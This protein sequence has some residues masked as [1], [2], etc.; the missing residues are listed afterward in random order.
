MGERRLRV[1]GVLLCLEVV[2][3]VKAC[4]EERWQLFFFFFFLHLLG[5]GELFSD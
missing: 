2:Q 5:Y 1:P 3:V 4:L